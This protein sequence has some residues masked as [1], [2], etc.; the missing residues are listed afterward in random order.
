MARSLQNRFAAA[1]AVSRGVSPRLAATALVLLLL[2]FANFGSV[3][4]QPESIFRLPAGTRIV[5][6][7]DAEINSRSSSVND[8]FIAYAAKPVSV[9]D[10]AVLPEGAIFEG[11]IVTVER[12]KRGSQAGSI[13][14]A[15]DSI[16]L[17]KGSMPVSAA[18]ITQ[19]K[20]HGSHALRFLSILGG[21]AAGAI[22]GGASNSTTGA[23]I[24]AG[25]GAG[26]GTGA[27]MLK[28]GQEMR[29]KRGEEFEIELKR[30]LLLPVLDY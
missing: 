2:I 14:I 27:A 30:D 17:G 16:K 8:T 18:V 21:V 4:S 20:P 13:T 11:R 23:L 3:R 28:K 19:F 7:M 22:I 5:L 1:R 6:K 15:I 12:A 26:A 25:I 29:I 10:A 9:R 24:G